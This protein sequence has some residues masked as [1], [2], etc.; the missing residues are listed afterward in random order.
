MVPWAKEYFAIRVGPEVP[1][2]QGS[3][4][5]GSL[6]EHTATVQKASPTPP[7]TSHPILLAP[8]LHSAFSGAQ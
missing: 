5:C 2:P 8:E 1:I 4:Q 7:L 3:V 6:Q